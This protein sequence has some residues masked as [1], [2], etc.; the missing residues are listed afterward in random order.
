MRSL[1]RALAWVRARVGLLPGGPGGRSG[2]VSGGLAFGKGGV[3]RGAEFLEANGG[4]SLLL[5]KKL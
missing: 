1:V 5:A 2:L 4:L 3:L